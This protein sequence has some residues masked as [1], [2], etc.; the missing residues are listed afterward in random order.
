MH[1]A[2]L[3]IA[4]SNSASCIE[5][6]Y[7]LQKTIAQVALLIIQQVA[8]IVRQVASTPNIGAIILN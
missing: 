3:Q 6:F 7:K 4:R 8:L 2:A 5:L 1:R